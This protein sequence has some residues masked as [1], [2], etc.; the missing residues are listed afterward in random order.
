MKNGP[1]AYILWRFTA[2]LQIS[3]ASFFSSLLSIPSFLLPPSLSLSISLALGFWTDKCWQCSLPHWTRGRLWRKTQS[4]PPSCNPVLFLLFTSLSRPVV[5]EPDKG[6]ILCRVSPPQTHQE[7]RWLLHK[8]LYTWAARHQ[9]K[10]NGQKSTLMFPG[11]EML[12]WWGRLQRPSVLKTAKWRTSVKISMTEMWI[13]MTQ[14]DN[15]ALDP[16]VAGLYFLSV[17]FAVTSYCTTNA[18]LNS[19]P[20]F[21]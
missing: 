17:P 4:P 5:C 18:G 14:L 19:M 21:L 15:A 8:V 12:P 6:L 20:L 7:Q 16:S 1:V 13:Q 3:A 9:R 2:A 10:I 11:S